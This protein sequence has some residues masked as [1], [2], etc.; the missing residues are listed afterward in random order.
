[1][2][3]R[4]VLGHDNIGVTD[5]FFE[6]G[7]DSIL[8]MRL[9]SRVKNS[10]QKDL[11]LQSLFGQ[12]VLADCAALIAESAHLVLPPIEARAEE[13]ERLPL[14]HAQER[15]WFLWNLIPDDAG[16]NIT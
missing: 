14:S 10:L 2:V 3:W 8:A 13:T 6:V 15:L 12:P 4:E 7:G 1:A 11:P 5:N 9:V 16:Y